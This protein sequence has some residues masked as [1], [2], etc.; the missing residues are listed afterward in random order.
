MTISANHFA[1]SRTLSLHAHAATSQ[2]IA[3][4]QAR[5]LSALLGEVEA[6]SVF[7][8]VSAS[9]ANALQ[10]RCITGV[11]IR[12]LDAYLPP[13]PLIY[14]A[15]ALDL[16][17]SDQDGNIVAAAQLLY[18]RIALARRQS[19]AAIRDNGSGLSDA[20]RDTMADAWQRACGAA[21]ALGT[22]LRASLAHC[23]SEANRVRPHRVVDLLRWAQRGEHPCVQQ[24]GSIVIPGWAERRRVCRQSIAIPARL[25]RTGQPVEV[26]VRDISLGGLG[27]TGISGAVRG[28]PAA[29]VFP[30]GRRLTGTVAWTAADRAGLKLDEPLSVNDPLLRGDDE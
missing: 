9:I 18:A 21:L 7:V 5:L 1:P 28:E 24:D 30:C 20:Q 12:A 2:Q 27:M 16:I 6:M 22:A 17:D 10:S 13:D 4:A 14:N 23:P 11:D 3:S 19:L 25:E 15:A 29:I 8:A 26:R